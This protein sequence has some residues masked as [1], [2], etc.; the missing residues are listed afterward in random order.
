MRAEELNGTSGESFAEGYSRGFRKIELASIAAFGLMMLG[1]VAKSAGR[2]AER[3]WLVLAAVLCG[4]LAADFV[5]G[6]VHW[7]GDT[8]GSERTPIL[9]RS[10]IRPFREH[11]VDQKAITRHDFVETNGA[12]CLISLPPLLLALLVPLGPGRLEALRLFLA[13]FLGALVLWVLATNQLHKWSHADRPPAL[14]ARLQRLHLVLPPAHHAIHHQAPYSR[15]YCITVG[16][17]NW[18]LTKLRLFPILER[19][20]AATLGL[21]PREGGTGTG[22]PSEAA[23]RLSVER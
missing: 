5:S 8:W 12:N 4:Y 20:V 10:L 16:W 17:L 23:S 6:V 14:I 3:P 9:G 18:P 11:H 22:G 1:L 2:A 15:Y 21:T 19:L 13:T 7:M